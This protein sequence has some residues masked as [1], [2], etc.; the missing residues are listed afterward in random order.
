MDTK[1]CSRCG[2]SETLMRGK[3]ERWYDIWNINKGD[4]G[5][6]A[7]TQSE[8]REVYRKN[9]AGTQSSEYCRY[10]RS[11]NGI[12]IQQNSVLNQSNSQELYTKARPKHQESI[13]R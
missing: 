7:G 12:N 2:N 5:S 10:Y 4:F 1:R 11:T 6:E 8:K 9:E 3:R 13:G